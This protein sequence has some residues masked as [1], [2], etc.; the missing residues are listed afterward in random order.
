MTT[1]GINE[2]S[3]SPLVDLSKISDNLKTLLTEKTSVI[4]PTPPPLPEPIMK[5]SIPKIGGEDEKSLISEIKKEE[6]KKN[7][8]KDFRAPMVL[9]EEPKKEKTE[10]IFNILKQNE[11][12]YNINE[13]LRPKEQ[14]INK[15]IKTVDAEQSKTLN[16]ENNF[17]DNFNKMNEVLDRR[18]NS[19]DSSVDLSNKNIQKNGEINT[20][21]LSANV[22]LSDDFTKGI[23]NITNV[24]NN[25]VNQKTTT[26]LR[27][28]DEIK[29]LLSKNQSQTLVDKLTTVPSILNQ[30]IKL[31]DNLANVKPEVGMSTK[32]NEDI[33]T[34]TKKTTELFNDISKIYNPNSLI[35]KI[36]ESNRD[37]YGTINKVIT[38]VRD[39]SVAN[40]KPPVTT[41]PIS[42]VIPPAI[43]NVSNVLKTET[44]T[45]DVN[46]KFDDIKGD[47]TINV[48][49]MPNLESALNNPQFIGDLQR[50]IVNH[51]VNQKIMEG[52]GNYSYNV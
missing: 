22:K 39:E 24:E 49:N 34:T 41:V 40:V 36:D 29:D 47:I 35:T 31:P 14:S 50:K 9:P 10:P 4:T 28:T 20:Q 32:V 38:P 51:V 5:F 42:N 15:E 52:T 37:L 13:P 8:V 7:E 33:I 44:V 26:E 12:P 27:M 19:Q 25:E 48:P 43:T 2:P 17:L 11:T 16:F 1:V 6:T 46:H 18:F 23:S 21:I 30:N 45:K 3:V